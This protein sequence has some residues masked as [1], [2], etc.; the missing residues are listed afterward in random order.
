[1]QAFNKFILSL[2]KELNTITKT[3]ILARD[4]RDQVAIEMLDDSCTHWVFYVTP[5]EGQFAGIQHDFELYF[6]NS[7][8]HYRPYKQLLCY[9]DTCHPN[10]SQESRSVCITFD[11]EIDTLMGFANMLLWIMINPDYSDPYR[12]YKQKTFERKTLK[13]FNERQINRYHK[14]HSIPLLL[15]NDVLADGQYRSKGSTFKLENGTVRHVSGEIAVPSEA[16]RMP[17]GTP[18]A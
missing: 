16:G 5:H 1:M 8:Y 9:T 4:T 18:V 3:G 17:V 14:G 12:G 11:D 15:V 10:V 6:V 13:C 2:A 7:A